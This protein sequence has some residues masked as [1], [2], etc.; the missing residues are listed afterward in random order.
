VTQSFEIPVFCVCVCDDAT[1]GV[2]KVD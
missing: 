1:N 2:R